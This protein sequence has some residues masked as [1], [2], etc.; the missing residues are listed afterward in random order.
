M[1]WCSASEH[2]NIIASDENML[3][4]DW[5]FGNIFRFLRYAE[6]IFDFNEVIID[7]SMK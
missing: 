2:N 6:N 1:F 7:S 4:G 3:K 5:G